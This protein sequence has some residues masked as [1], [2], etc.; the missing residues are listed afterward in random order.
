MSVQELLRPS[1]MD[2][3]V[4][5]DEMDLLEEPEYQDEIMDAELEPTEEE[6]LDVASKEDRDALQSEDLDMD[7]L[8]YEANEVPQDVTIE[9]LE[10]VEN[11][12]VRDVP[13]VDPVDVH[14]P[15]FAG[16][17]IP[18]VDNEAPGLRNG[19]KE[20]DASFPVETID[21]QQQP[22][23][24]E[25]QSKQEA[26]SSAIA[27]RVDERFEMAERITE[28]T[29]DELQSPQVQAGT[30][31]PQLQQE[32][33]G[34]TIDY[35]SGDN[36]QVQS[37]DRSPPKE[38]DQ[39]SEADVA[40]QQESSNKRVSRG[41]AGIETRGEDNHD[42]SSNVEV[43]HPITISF[44]DT[45]MSLFAPLDADTQSPQTFLLDDRNLASQSFNVLFQACR[46]LLEGSIE[47]YCE[48]EMHFHDL[49]LSISEVSDEVPSDS[50]TM[51]ADIY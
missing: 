1:S 10:P 26:S 34:A 51:D 6:M 3:N 36:G 37:H 25:M 33:N 42:G 18:S 50:S 14:L 2:Q 40:A 48:F 7:E 47:D 43:A 32:D 49:Q 5:Q 9:E 46:S 39:H 20:T 45:E 4:F 22:V 24:V 19:S 31:R 44:Q 17:Q 15:N 8:N 13:A 11:T 28:N 30:S 21:T 38:M 29:S 27:D 12:I 16:D 35:T 41:S 23:T